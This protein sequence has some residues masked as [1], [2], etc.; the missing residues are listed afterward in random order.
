MGCLG[1]QSDDHLV[2]WGNLFQLG[3]TRKPESLCFAFN[4][5]L[6]IKENKFF[7]LNYWK[8]PS[9]FPNKIFPVYQGMV[10]KEFEN[11][12]HS[13]NQIAQSSRINARDA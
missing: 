3:A 12:T 5:V 7:A 4:R 6:S 2:C 11:K 10:I 8:F 13:F 9:E 1:V